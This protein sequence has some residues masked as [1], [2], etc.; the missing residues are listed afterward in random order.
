L[1][2]RRGRLLIVEDDRPSGSA[3]KSILTSHG[4]EVTLATT[5]AQAMIVLGSE[6]P[7][8][9]LLD[10]MLPDGTGDVV[11]RR[12]RAENLSTR[13]VVTTAVIDSEILK[14]VRALNP[15]AM[16]Q[17]PL[18]LRKLLANLPNDA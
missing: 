8:V 13:V 1:L 16:M 15:F 4:W 17:K 5:V 10:L 2:R 14:Q 7:K 12:I 9:I 6:N 18:D 3:L 11:L